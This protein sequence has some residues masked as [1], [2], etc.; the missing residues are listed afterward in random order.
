MKHL[1]LSL[2]LTFG[3]ISTA[4][5]GHSRFPYFDGG[6]SVDGRFVVTVI[7]IDTPP[8]NKKAP[9]SYHWTYIWKDTTTGKT[10]DGRL[11]DGYRTG[12][13]SVFDPVHGHTFVAPDGETFAIWN[14]QVLAP[15]PA[16]LKKPPTTFDSAESR[17]FVGFSH[18][19]VIYRKT[20]EVVKRFDLKDFLHEG[21][22]E[23]LYC[24]GCQV[25]WQTE[26]D[27]LTT[28]TAPRPGYALY[29]IS[30]DSTV[31]EFTIGATE[32]AKHKAKERGITP[33]APRVVRVSLIDGRDLS[34]AKLTEPAKVPV[35]PFK[36][37]T[38]GT[39]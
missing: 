14:P 5:A 6:Q 37:H 11:A 19:L 4:D 31:L 39:P 8:A 35:R 36:G 22:W 34:D 17:D 21:D 2:C 33:P 9:A 24:Y 29:R 13:D 32:E 16:G 12:S 20:G 3:V 30:P 10:I 25:Y 38:K 15:T 27:G 23:W 1:L 28:R 18:R 26:Y 7:R